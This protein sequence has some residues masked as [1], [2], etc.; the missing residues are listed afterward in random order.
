MIVKKDLQLQDPQL[1][2]PLKDPQHDQQ[3]VHLLLSVVSP[4]AALLAPLPRV[5]GPHQVVPHWAGQEFSLDEVYLAEI[6]ALPFS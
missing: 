4:R 3:G 1:Q 2:D 6:N 5:V